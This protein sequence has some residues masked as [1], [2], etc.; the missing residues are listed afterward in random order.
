MSNKMLI[1][2]AGG[3]T[4]NVSLCCNIFTK[5]RNRHE[6]IPLKRI[7]DNNI[8]VSHFGTFSYIGWDGN[9]PY[10]SRIKMCQ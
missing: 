1:A 3:V 7:V 4:F 10:T 5:L 6:R 8:I 2:D 9:S